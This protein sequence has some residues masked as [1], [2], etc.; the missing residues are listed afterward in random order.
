MRKFVTGLMAA[1]FVAVTVMAT[2]PAVMAW[3]E[4][5]YKGNGK[6][7]FNTYTDVPNVGSEKDFFKVGAVDATAAQM[8]NVLEV[9]EGKARFTTYIHNGAPES[10]NGADNTGTGVA[11]NTKL[12][13]S[14]Q[15]NG[16]QDSKAVISASNA[17]SVSDTATIKCGDHDIEVEYVED[18]ATIFTQQRGEQK[19]S[20]A[21]VSGGTLV[22]TYKDDGIVPGCWDYRV[23][24]SVIVKVKKVE[25]PSVTPPPVTPPVTPPTTPPVTQL[26]KTGAGSVA[27]IV[28]AVT[29]GGAFAHRLVLS[30]RNS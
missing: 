11:K 15:T 22:G 7:V 4:D 16:K 6:P 9:C 26:P 20:N 1:A 17:P 18:S 21:V 28:A 27:G 13:I 3:G 24:V 2:S 19:L 8:G 10:Y 30:R 23:Y 5:E 25:E 14:L 29:A 12:A